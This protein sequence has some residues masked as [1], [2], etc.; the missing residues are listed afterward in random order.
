[1]I[2]PTSRTDLQRG[3]NFLLFFTFRSSSVICYI[4]AKE[5]PRANCAPRDELASLI[6]WY[7]FS[8]GLSQTGPRAGAIDPRGRSGG[9][10]RRVDDAKGAADNK[11]LIHLFKW[12]FI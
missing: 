7:Y 1:M 12:R 9:V 11:F 5:S 3:V 8:T 6:C 4:L 10:T 2:N